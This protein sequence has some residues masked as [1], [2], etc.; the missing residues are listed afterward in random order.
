[1]APFLRQDV[2]EPDEI[3]ESGIAHHLF[4]RFAQPYEVDISTK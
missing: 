2:V 1:M 3:E 4:D